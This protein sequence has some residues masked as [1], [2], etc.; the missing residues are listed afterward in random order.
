MTFEL[1]H[2]VHSMCYSFLYCLL[3]DFMLYTGCL[4]G[5]SKLHLIKKNV[6]IPYKGQR[7][8]QDLHKHLR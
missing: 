3:F 8:S 5:R 7:R 6:S 4:F 1:M 2:S